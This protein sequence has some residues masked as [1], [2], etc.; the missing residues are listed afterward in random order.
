VT[1]CRG[2]KVGLAAAWGA[3]ILKETADR[4]RWGESVPWFVTP[5]N[6]LLWG[7]VA[8]LLVL[9]VAAAKEVQ[10]LHET[11]VQLRTLRQTMVTVQ[12]IVR[13]RLL[14]VT[15]A[16]DLL[17]AGIMPQPQHV[18]LLRGAVVEILALLNQLSRT[19]KVT[20]EQVGEGIQAVR[21]EP[22]EAQ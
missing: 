13:N 4:L 2:P 8:T 6:V 15:V 9:L 16:S 7:V 17:D 14:I 5:C 20:V 10:R 18:K 19:Q 22:P 1:I 3:A 11:E 21:I 12:D